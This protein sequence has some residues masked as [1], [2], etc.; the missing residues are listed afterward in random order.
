MESPQTTSLR[1]GI[2]DEA[3][4]NQPHR[5]PALDCVAPARNDGL[6]RDRGGHAVRAA[7]DSTA[8]MWM[9]KHEPRP[10]S[11]STVISPPIMRHSR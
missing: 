3:I 5:S 4:Q 9:V 10:G 1:G 8:G 7:A 2:A 6:Y 11:L